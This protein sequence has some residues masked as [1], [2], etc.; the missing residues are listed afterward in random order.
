ML[1]QKILREILNYDGE[2]GVFTWKQRIGSA[3]TGQRAGSMHNGHWI[4][5]LDGKTQMAARLAWLYEYGE[6]PT[7]VLRFKDGDTT[8]VAIANL[9][10]STANADRLRDADAAKAYKAELR[11]KA[12]EMTQ[13]NLK[14]LLHYDP[15]TGIFSWLASG[16][17]RKLGQPAGSVWGDGYRFIH[18]FGRDI[19]AARLAWL[20]VYG[21]LPEGKRI[22]FDDGDPKNLRITNLRPA[23]TVA[24]LNKRFRTK[25]PNSVRNSELKKYDG[26]TL[27]QYNALLEAQ[28]G[29]CAVCERPETDTDNTGTGKVR[30]LNVDHD[31]KTGAV[32]GLLCSACNR[33]A[34]LL[35]DD[36]VRALSLAT[37]LERHM[38]KAAA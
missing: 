6:W 10:L 31:H 4:I 24:E 2:T 7:T 20:Y 22:R 35:A 18:I 11:A 38:K 25:N 37:Y 12:G 21:E 26:M 17:G 8:N 16:S 9:K 27:S 3:V 29:V 5:R 19:Q 34:G 13:E 15:E 36:P 32:R 30:N 28:G 33:A 1:D 23:L 14:K